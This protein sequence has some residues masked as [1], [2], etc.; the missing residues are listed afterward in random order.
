MKDPKNGWTQKLEQIEKDGNIFR[1]W[2]KKTDGTAN[3][4][5]VQCL[6]KGIKKETLVDFM[7][8]IE[9]EM[10]EMKHL[11][12]FKVLEVDD[13]GLP[14]II[15]SRN[16]LPMMTDRESLIRQTRKYLDGDKTLTITQSVDHPDYPLTPSAIRMDMFKAAIYY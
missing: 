12:Q 4:M 14:L 2:Q 15:Y 10:K 9:S 13:Q 11:K 1:F 7:Q 6:L 16:K 5:C 3:I 8:N